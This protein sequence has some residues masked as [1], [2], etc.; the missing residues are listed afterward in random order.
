MDENATNPCMKFEA[1]V[2]RDKALSLYILGHDFRHKSWKTQLNQ[3][4]SYENTP[5]NIYN[6]FNERCGQLETK[7]H[8]SSL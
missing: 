7:T 5:Q 6:I 2:T 8:K 1:I 3:I 4:I